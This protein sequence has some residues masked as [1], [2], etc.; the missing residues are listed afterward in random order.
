MPVTENYRTRH[1]AND[2]F[3]GR[4]FC[5]DS[6][7]HGD[8]SQR[9]HLILKGPGKDLEFSRYR[10]QQRAPARLT[11]MDATSHTSAKL[12]GPHSSTPL[13]SATP[14]KGGQELRKTCP[15]KSAV[16]APGG[17]LGRLKCHKLATLSLSTGC[18]GRAPKADGISCQK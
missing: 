1:H 14:H 13:P 2:Q 6:T 16:P 5:S 15:T 12:F 9:R 18:G 3:G 7:S 8:M 17:I 4:E 11:E 10:N